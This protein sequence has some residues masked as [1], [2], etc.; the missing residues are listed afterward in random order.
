M[1]A[2]PVPCYRQGRTGV[3]GL[4]LLIALPVL[5]ALT[6][7][8]VYVGL[9]RDVRYEA[10]GGADAAALA[11]ARLLADDSL[12]LKE[13][14]HALMQGRVRQA[15]QMA[16]TIGQLN[17]AGNKRLS[18]DLNDPNNPEGDIV[19]GQLD[20]PLRGTFRPLPADV[21]SWDNSAINAV[22]VTVRRSALPGLWGGRPPQTAIAAQATAFLDWRVVGY[23]PSHDRPIPLVPI[24]LYSDPS[25]EDARS[26]EW[27]WQRRLCD[28]WSYDR[29]N[30][31]WQTGAD[32]LP[33]IVQTL[34]G[35]GLTVGPAL[36]LQIGV[37]DFAGTLHQIQEGIRRVELERQFGA[38]GFVLRGDNKV[39]VP[40]ASGLPPV[41]S[42]TRTV[43]LET[44]QDLASTGQARLWPLYS[45]Y[46]TLQGQVR[47]HG[48]TAA[49][50]V[51]IQTQGTN[52]LLVLQ[53]CVLPHAAAV[54]EQRE[55]SPEFW[56]NNRMVCRVRLAE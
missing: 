32:G 28:I 40:G 24:A 8:V 45:V 49:R 47:V 27:Q 21:D 17:F 26:W 53:P 23:R 37:E 50:L 46:D 12:L 3:S 6:G 10:Q 15:R 11:G 55:P 9:L 38:G 52:L 14:Y 48:W 5:L 41:G 54:T 22:R 30:Q 56:A 4:S 25:G 39:N 1:F 51:E 33:E 19:I 13:N 29:S 2:H 18:L 7:L 36:F 31:R 35:T 43:L 34:G 44:L 20:R 42:Q 16:Q